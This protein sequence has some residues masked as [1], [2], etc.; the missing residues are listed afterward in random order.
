MSTL[1]VVARH[2]ERY[3]VFALTA[4]AKVDE[5]AVQCEKFRPEVAVVGSA[6]AAQR[7]SALLRDSGVSTE[8]TYGEASL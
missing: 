1:D 3:R 2:P 7:L 8:V 6:E 4:H 5:L